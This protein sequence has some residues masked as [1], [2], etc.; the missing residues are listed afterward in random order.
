[1][2][3][4]IFSIRKIFYPSS[5]LKQSFKIDKNGNKTLINL[6]LY[7]DGKITKIE[8]NKIYKMASSKYILSE[9]SGDDFAKGVSYEI[10][11]SKYLENKI[12]CSDV[13]IDVE[14]ANY[15]RGKGTVNLSN[16]VDPN[17]PRIVKFF[18]N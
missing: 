13:T 15:F 4:T 5:K 16:K 7:V 10:I 9:T 8:D 3:I 6:E 2:L 11:H 12:K 17:N 18:E 14:I 1:M